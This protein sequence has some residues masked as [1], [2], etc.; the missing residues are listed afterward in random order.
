LS[1]TR[2]FY[3]HDWRRIEQRYSQLKPSASETLKMLREPGALA[4]WIHDVSGLQ[5]VKFSPPTVSNIT[6]LYERAQAE[7][8]QRMEEESADARNALSELEFSP[9]EVI[10]LPAEEVEQYTRDYDI[11]EPYDPEVPTRPPATI[12]GF[13]VS[14]A[15]NLDSQN[16]REVLRRSVI[17]PFLNLHYPEAADKIRSILEMHSQEDLMSYCCMP[18]KLKSFVKRLDLVRCKKKIRA[19]QENDDEGSLFTATA[20]DPFVMLPNEPSVAVLE[21]ELSSGCEMAQIMSQFNAEWIKILQISMH[22]V[23]SCSRRLISTASIYNQQFSHELKILQS[24]HFDN[25]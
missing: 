24:S 25:P 16:V 14:I 18:S 21:I 22:Q 17:T 10:V 8:N 2:R 13:D 6:S 11:I 9:Q 20:E 1:Y 23:F 7:L 3:P 4:N 15:E 5:G 19:A 12:V